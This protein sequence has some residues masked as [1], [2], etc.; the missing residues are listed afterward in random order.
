MLSLCFVCALAGSRDLRLLLVLALGVTPSSR[1]SSRALS[2]SVS[3]VLFR[4]GSFCISLKVIHSFAGMLTGFMLL[5]NTVL[6]A[7]DVVSR[8]VSHPRSL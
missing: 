4:Q 6:S 8:F 5:R 3:L 2:S 1:V 7:K